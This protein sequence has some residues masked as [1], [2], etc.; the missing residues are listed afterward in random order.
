M[1]ADD[2]SSGEGSITADD[3]TPG[4]TSSEPPVLAV[5]DNQTVGDDK[6]V[7][8]GDNLIHLCVSHN[9]VLIDSS[10]NTLQADETCTESHSYVNDSAPLMDITNNSHSDININMSFP[11]IAS[12]TPN[13]LSATMQDIFTMTSPAK[14]NY[15]LLSSSLQASPTRPLSHEERTVFTHLVRRQL[16]NSQNNIIECKTKGQPLLL[17]RMSKSRVDSS[18]ASMR[19]LQRRTQNIK[20][21]RNTIA[22]TSKDSTTTQQAHE[23]RG[24]RKSKVFLQKAGIVL[25]P[26]M[27]CMTVLAMKESI[28]LS[29][30]ELKRQRRFLKQAGIAMPSEKQLRKAQR[31]LAVTDI[32]TCTLSFVGKK[33]HPVK[34]AFG[35]VSNIKD[36]VFNLLD[37][38]KKH[39]TLTWFNFVIPGDEIWIKFGGDHGKG[40]MKFTMQ[41]ANT[42]K[43]NSKYNTFVVAMAN[44]PD[45]HSN[46]IKWMSIL[47]P[48]LK[49]LANSEWD[50]KR[51]VIF[52]FGDY[53]FLTKIYGLSGAGGK[54]PCLW[55]LMPLDETR[56]GSNET[57]EA[58]SVDS[59]K[60]DNERFMGEGK[61]KHGDVQA[62]N[63]CLHPPNTAV[64]V[65]AVCPPYLHIMLGLVHKH[66]VLLEQES[67]LLDLD[68][69]EQAETHDSGES[70]SL[71][72]HGNNWKMAEEIRDDIFWNKSLQYWLKYPHYILSTHEKTEFKTKFFEV[73]ENIQTS[74][75]MFELLDHKPLKPRAGPVCSGLDRILDKHGI[76][77]QQYHKRAFVGNHCHK[78]LAKQTVFKELTSYVVEKTK[79][80]TKQWKIISKAR[81]LRARFDLLNSAY[82]DVH[83]AISHSKS[84]DREGT[85]KIQKLID[86]Y[87]L[88]FKSKF[89]KTKLTPK[90]HILLKHC[91]PWIRKYGFGLGL[92]GEQGGELIHATV[93]K[94]ERRSRCIRNAETRLRFI[95]QTQH[96]QV[97]P[98][99]RAC[100][101]KVKKRKKRASL[102]I[103]D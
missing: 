98:E 60:K 44:V 59:L 14:K 8:T 43:P 103:V 23:I 69:K 29:W 49:Q 57:Y 62:Y 68:I 102:K 39:Q 19:T 42:Y 64:D 85:S 92:M 56:K 7:N 72:S 96:L 77:P 47:E 80:C 1:N 74:I 46:I 86:K 51:V 38:H 12:S 66:H 90:Q 65:D 37:K 48:E 75:K 33:N 27:D 5:T 30:D 34:E 53:E 13:K 52:D 79:S 89:S 100:I 20:H 45:N 95:M 18:V 84:I 22:G 71:R 82:L 87:I 97:C 36:F 6:E 9:G 2:R 21:I 26:E 83:N 16:N 50:G 31:A 99:L 4:V 93:A 94:L 70:A 11:P 40:S 73:G 61:G 55:C 32:D 35:K 17:G 58:R 15:T 81:V 25:K 88:L 54:H 76:V 41:I 91:V 67:H 63:N 78:Y 101:P 3:S 10:V 24:L 28:D